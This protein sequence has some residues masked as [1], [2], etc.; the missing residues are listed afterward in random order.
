MK[1]S[2]L[3]VRLQVPGQLH[4]EDGVEQGGDE[5]SV[6]ATHGPK[7]LE[8]QQP[9]RHAVLLQGD[10]NKGGAKGA[11][12]PSKLDGSSETSLHRIFNNL[13]S[14]NTKPGT[15]RSHSG[16]PCTSSCTPPDPRPSEEEE[17]IRTLAL[18]NRKKISSYLSFGE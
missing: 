8:E 4:G 13:P 14:D 10:R 15:A 7:H 3:R 1:V 11:A 5:S 2:T 17:I 6:Q 12:A 18:A 9:Q 16:C